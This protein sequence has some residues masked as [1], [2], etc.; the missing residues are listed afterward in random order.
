MHAP[1]APGGLSRPW[2]FEATGCH[3]TVNTRTQLPDTLRKRI[4]KRVTTFEDVWSR[5]RPGSLVRRA[6]AGAFP[7][8]A[9]GAVELSL[10]A[11][12][13]TLLELYDRLHAATGGRIDPLVGADLTALGYDAEY[14]FVVRDGAV[15]RLRADHGRPTWA[16]TARHDGDRLVLRESALIDVGAVGKGFLADL[17]ADWLKDADQEEY[18]IDASGDLLVRCSEPV[19]VGLER[20]GARSGGEGEVVGVVELTDGAVC[21]SGIS[22]RTWGPGLHHI[23]DAH[24][25]LPVQGM[26]AVI[27]TW[28]VASSCAVADGLATALFVSD[29][30]A[31]AAAGFDYD[32]AL[33]RADGSAAVSRTWHDLPAAL[34][35]APHR[36]R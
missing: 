33:L 10:P 8:R 34:F 15:H 35:T 21:A 7:R 24:T 25:G 3:W 9:D 31:L 18:V 32:F 6:A 22:R 36:D 26:N 1:S 2:C 17:L 5:F 30:A 4:T 29:P 16:D 20:P 12:S 14:S 27:A 13:S 28:A 11:R 23:L 19:R